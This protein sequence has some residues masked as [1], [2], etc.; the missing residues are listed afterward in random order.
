MII[1]RYVF[2]HKNVV[3]KIKH[4]FYVENSFSKNLAVYMIMRKYMVQLNRPRI[5]V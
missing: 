1:S 4:K 2:L 3:E 5:T